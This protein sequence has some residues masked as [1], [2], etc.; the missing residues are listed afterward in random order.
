[1]LGNLIAIIKANIAATL[2][3][4][5]ASEISLLFVVDS[6]VYYRMAVGGRE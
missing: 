3:A 6:Q 2:N 4:R 5:K 1:M